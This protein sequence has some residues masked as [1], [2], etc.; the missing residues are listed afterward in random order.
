MRENEDFGNI[1]LVL[2]LCI[3]ML[4]KNYNKLKLHQKK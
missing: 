3:I 2:S 1:I 4:E